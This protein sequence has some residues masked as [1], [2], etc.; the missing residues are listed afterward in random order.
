LALMIS[1]L[2][3]CFMLP[4]H[5]KN[6]YA[7]Q[8]AVLTNLID[9]AEQSRQEARSAYSNRRLNTAIRHYNTLSERCTE[10]PGLCNSDE[11]EEIETRLQELNTIKDRFDQNSG[12]LN[13][14]LNNRNCDTAKDLFDNVVDLGAEWRLLSAGR[15]SEFEQRLDEICQPPPPETTTNNE[16]GR[17]ILDSN[18]EAEIYIEG[19]NRGKTP[20][21]LMLEPDKYDILLQTKAEICRDC[22]LD[23]TILLA[24]GQQ[25]EINRNFKIGTC[26][27]G[28]KPSGAIVFIDETFSIVTPDSVKLSPGLHKMRGSLDNKSQV[29]YKD[30]NADGLNIVFFDLQ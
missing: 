16:Y 23:T 10:C 15:R 4:D 21:S 12:N 9:N 24:T 6:E 2:F 22:K 19:Q 17:L 27:I 5:V 26:R 1:K 13:Y 30:I 28:S 20:R 3:F 8:V 7:S 18:P 14:H 29:R 11:Q 25:V